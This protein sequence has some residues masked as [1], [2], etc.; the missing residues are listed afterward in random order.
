M[1]KIKNIDQ[2]KTE[3][4]ILFKTLKY[5]V[6]TQPG[7]IETIKKIYSCKFRNSITTHNLY[8]LIKKIDKSY[9]NFVNIR[10]DILKKYNKST[11]EKIEVDEEE[12]GE[13]LEKCKAA[14]EKTFVIPNISMKIAD[15]PN[16]FTPHDFKTLEIILTL[17]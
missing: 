17:N 3:T 9:I 4:E 14:L 8:I 10:K 13:Y 2:K 5:E 12:K 6:F 11:S 16:D 7:F 1:S 15:I